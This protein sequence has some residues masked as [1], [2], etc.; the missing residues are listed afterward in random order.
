M[1]PKCRSPVMEKSAQEPDAHL[2]DEVP[3]FLPSIFSPWRNQKEFFIAGNEPAFAHSAAQPPVLPPQTS[4][5][6]TTKSQDISEEDISNYPLH[7][8]TSPFNP[9]VT[10]KTDTADDKRASRL[11][12][13]GMQP[14]TEVGIA[15]GN[16]ATANLEKPGPLRRTRFKEMLDRSLPTTLF[17][18]NSFSRISGNYDEI[19]EDHQAAPPHR[20]MEN[21]DTENYPMGS[22]NNAREIPEESCASSD[23]SSDIEIDDLAARYGIFGVH[24]C[25]LPTVFDT[26]RFSRATTPRLLL[27]AGCIHQALELGIRRSSFIVLVLYTSKRFVVYNFYLP[28]AIWKRDII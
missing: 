21:R 3:I 24:S 4:R 26:N 1:I 20:E 19:R 2:A 11:F 13:H 27:K 28:T 23:D 8:P 9:L 12:K 6:T 14:R 15:A 22:V 7:Q 25:A 16:S 10:G 5:E 18:S 17:K